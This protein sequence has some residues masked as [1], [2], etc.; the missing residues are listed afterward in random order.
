M[1]QRILVQLEVE[2]RHLKSGQRHLILALAQTYTGSTEHEVHGRFLYLIGST[3][4]GF[5]I[6]L[7]Q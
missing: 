3:F 7:Y 1:C 2:S 5:Y 4:S 6:H